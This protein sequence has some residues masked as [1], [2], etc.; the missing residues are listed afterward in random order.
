MSDN[1][2]AALN[3]IDVD[4][5]G[6]FCDLVMTIDGERIIIKSPTTPQDLSVCFMNAVEDAAD[7][8][9]MDVSELLPRIDVVR[10][11]TTVALNRLIQRQGPRIG[12]ITSEGQEDAILIGRGAQWVDGKR[13]AQRRNLAVQSKPTP[14][15][16]R[17]MIVGVKERVDSTGSVIRPLDENDVR[18]KLKQLMDNGARAIVVSLLWSFA[19]PAHERRI[20]EIIREEY[21]EFHVGYLPV[22]L[23]SEVVAKLGEYERTMT[24][25]LDAYLQQIMQIELSSTWDKVRAHGFNNSFLMIHNS[26]GSAELFKTTACRTFNGGPVAGL[27]G[28]VHFASQLGYNNVVACDMGGT[29][30]DVGLVV[31]SSVRNY[32]F[33]PIIDTWMVGVT[34]LQTTSVGAGGGSIASLDPLLGNRLDVG[35]RSAGSM[36]GPVCYDLGGVEPTVTDA[37]LVLGYLSDKNYFGGQMQLSKAK[38]ERAIEKNIADPLEISVP[39]AAALIRHVVDQNMA[40]AIKREVHLRGY[41]PEDFV[42]FAFGGAGPTHVA[43]FKGDIDKAVIFPTSPVFC[44]MGASVMDIVH[45]YEMSKRMMFMEAITENMT[46][47]Y[48]TFNGV[49]ELLVE[50]A[51]QDLMA[52]GLPVDQAIFSLE[53]DMLYGGQVNV[54]RMASPHLYIRSENDA[55]DVYEAFELEFSEAFSPLVVNKP[56]GVYLDSYVLRVSVPTQKVELAELPITGADASAARTGTRQAYWPEYAEYVETTVYS[57]DELQPGNRFVGPAIVEADLTTVVVAPEQ[58]FSIDKYGLGILEGNTASTPQASQTSS[59]VSVRDGA[60]SEIEIQAP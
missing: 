20:K 41:K 18:R 32:E 14:L 49:V 8:F 16:T 43:G 5:G 2:V 42:L 11:S 54:K 3:S 48:E 6:T 13:V 34:M 1:S 19:N 24:T 50:R 10:Y 12:L 26:G 31:E 21:K 36:P 47:E 51:K 22:V 53:L 29:S 38:A 17:P 27:M 37:D 52:E 55:R 9:D 33:R 58:T 60:R 57:F 45:I 39:E 35:P 23:S 44:A 28:S 25:V 7:E 4:I 46:T 56:G 59:A 40:S 15:V 30:F